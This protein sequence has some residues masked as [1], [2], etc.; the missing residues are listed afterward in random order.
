MQQTQ[1]SFSNPMGAS[2]APDPT[3]NMHDVNDAHSQDYGRDR[4][5][6]LILAKLDAIKAELDS[7]HQRIRKIE[8]TTEPQQRRN[9][10]N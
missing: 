4:D 2:F 6:E 5:I 9:S 3:H 7:V 10:W 8:Q 1:Q